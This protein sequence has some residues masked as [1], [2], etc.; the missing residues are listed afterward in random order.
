VKRAAVAHTCPLTDESGWD[1]A[2]IECEP[3]CDSR[4]LCQVVQLRSLH[5]DETPSLAFIERPKRPYPVRPIVGRPDN[6]R[7]R[8]EQGFGRRFRRLVHGLT[9]SLLLALEDGD[10]VGVDLNGLA[11]LSILGVLADG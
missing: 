2:R 11:G 9:L 8:L 6:G 10:L 1:E 7:H 4:L 3:A 5:A